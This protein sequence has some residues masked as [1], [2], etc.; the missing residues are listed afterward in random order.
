MRSIVST[1]W[2]RMLDQ[3]FLSWCFWYSVLWCVVNKYTNLTSTVVK[4]VREGKNNFC[5]CSRQLI[6]WKAEMSQQCCVVGCTHTQNLRHGPVDPVLK[7]NTIQPRNQQGRW[8]ISCK[9]KNLEQQKKVWYTATSKNF[10]LKFFT[11][12][13]LCFNNMLS[14]F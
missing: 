10:S 5:F 13:L 12:L 11:Y 8:C 1:N 3:F 2:Q 6:A 14:N 9:A 4:P 7:T